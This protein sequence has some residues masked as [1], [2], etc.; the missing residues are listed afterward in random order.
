M[1]MNDPE[2]MLCQPLKRYMKAQIVKALYKATGLA[3]YSAMPNARLKEHAREVLCS[4]LGP[5]FSA[6]LDRLR[7]ERWRR[8]VE[9]ERAYRRLRGV[10]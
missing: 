2:L 8:R 9:A 5:E 7:D 1:V 10:G 4:P 6:D 3:G